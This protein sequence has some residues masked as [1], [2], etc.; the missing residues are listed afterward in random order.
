[1][2][3]RVLDPSPMLVLLAAALL[4]SQLLTASPV[5]AAKGSD[6]QPNVTALI[7]TISPD[8]TGAFSAVL[9][10]EGSSTLTQLSFTG[11]LS[12]GTFTGPLPGGCGLAG[13]ATVQCAVGSLPSGATASLVFL[14][15]SSGSELVLRGTFS[16]DAQQGNPNAAKDDTWTFDD[17]VGDEADL[18]RATIAVNGSDDFY[19]TWQDAHTTA[20]APIAVGTAFQ[21]A[22]V[23][24]PAF[25][26]NDYP[27]IV[28]QV[29]DTLGFTCEGVARTGFGKS[30]AL[31][32]A[33]GE[34]FETG[35]L[36]VSIR[37]S[38]DAAPQ[39]NP[40]QVS[41]AH[42]DDDGVCHVIPRDC[43]ATPGFCFD[44]RWDGRGANKAILVE[45][46]LPHNGKARGY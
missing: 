5:G 16:S 35:P 37:Y 11:L 12:G 39:R 21:R 45:V 46:Q 14:A 29:D 19:G 24:V 44:A 20:L 42:I 41:M 26:D 7:G 18:M 2:R 38:A 32:L 27:A 23:I 13:S 3:A 31:T 28:S 34:V 17:T 9:V 43:V 8:G 22:T 4:L 30:V 36:K 25:D 33:G 6:I 1:M 10:N 15:E 40:Q